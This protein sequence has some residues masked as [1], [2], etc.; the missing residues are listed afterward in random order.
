MITFC[1]IFKYVFKVMIFFH[2]S[3]TLSSFII[4]VTLSWIRFILSVGCILVETI[5]SHLEKEVK[6]R[7]CVD[8]NEEAVEKNNL[9]RMNDVVFQK[10]F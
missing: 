4:T 5:S 6:N 7:F 8:R 3:L 2:L 10:L 1:Q 9:L